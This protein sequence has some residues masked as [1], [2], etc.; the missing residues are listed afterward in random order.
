MKTLAPKAPIILL[1]WPLRF[2]RAGIRGRST[3]WAGI[4]YPDRLSDDASER[5]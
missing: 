2:A 4:G 3:D 5:E 1:L